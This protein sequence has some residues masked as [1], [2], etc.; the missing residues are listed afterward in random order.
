MATTNDKACLTKRQSSEAVYHDEQSRFFGLENL[1]V[2]KFFFARTS[3]ENR[4]FL[5]KIGG[6]SQLKG[7]RVLDLGCGI[8]DAAVFFALAQASVCGVD[9]SP[10]T[11]VSADRLSKE[12]DLPRGSLE[13]LVAP[14]ENLPYKN[15]SFDLVYGNGILHHVDIRLTLLEVKRALKPG[16]TAFFVE[17]LAYNPLVNF[18]RKIVKKNRSPFEKPLTRKDLGMIKGVFPSVQFEFF[19]LTS[20][21]VFIWMFFLGKRPDSVKY[22]KEVVYRSSRYERIFAPLNKLDRLLLKVFPPLRWLCWTVGIYVNGG[23]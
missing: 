1:D 14:A 15:E 4:F 2:R 22:W 5:D 23:I 7:K 3:V 12:Y 11:L 10:K 18:Y 6:A 13:L 21:L 17:P 8:G 19:W 16:G 9:I 20:L